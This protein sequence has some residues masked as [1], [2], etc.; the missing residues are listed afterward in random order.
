MTHAG[1]C[2]RTFEPEETEQSRGNLNRD[3]QFFLCVK[4]DDKEE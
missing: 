4:D 2:Q 1:I 3:K